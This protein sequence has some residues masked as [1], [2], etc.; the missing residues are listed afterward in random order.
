MAMRSK[1]PCGAMG[2]SELVAP[3]E[4]YCPVHKREVNAR[5]RADDLAVRSLYSYG[6]ARYSKG[7]LRRNPLCVVCQAAGRV[8]AAEVTDHIVPH[9][10]DRS[11]F[12]DTANHQA[13]CKSCHDRK[14]VLED[15]GFGRGR[16][17]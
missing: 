8:V 15:G 5:R 1:V 12:W 17:Y 6:W 9:R 16:V 13:L 3:P 7:F 2:C 4:R 10:G 14:T 11:L